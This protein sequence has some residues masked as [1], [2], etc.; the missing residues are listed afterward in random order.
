MSLRGI[1]RGPFLRG[2][3]GFCPFVHGFIGRCP[4]LVMA[5]FQVGCPE[6]LF[7]P[8]VFEQFISFKDLV[9]N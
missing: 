2:F 1:R 8:S 7:L 4:M 5:P 6:R 3:I 9:F